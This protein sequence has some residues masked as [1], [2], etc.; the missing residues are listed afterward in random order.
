[1]TRGRVHAG[2]SWGQGRPHLQHRPLG[3]PGLFA[4]SPTHGRC[5][6]PASRRPGPVLL[7][8]APE[9][10]KPSLRGGKRAPN[11]SSPTQRA[12]RTRPAADQPQLPPVLPIPARQGGKKRCSSASPIGLS[13]CSS[14]PWGEVRAGRSGWAARQGRAGCPLSP[15]T[16]AFLARSV[17]CPG[18]PHMSTRPA[19][20]GY[21][22]PALVFVHRTRVMDSAT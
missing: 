20:A 12:A 8:P 16:D 10:E 19:C 9:A 15:T 4:S 13:R 7:H 2:R 11:A 14:W 3:G 22:H 18:N 17:T 6:L 21:P 5:V 1:M